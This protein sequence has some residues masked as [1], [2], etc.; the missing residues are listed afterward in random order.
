[1]GIKIWVDDVR[2]MPKGYDFHFHSV[3]ETIDAID[4]IEAKQKYSIDLL[5]LD[6]DAGEFC[7]DGGDYIRILDYLEEHNI[8]IPIH[9]HSANV[10]GVNNMKR[11]IEKNN[12]KY[13]Y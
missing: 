12:W 4:Y 3:N 5:S 7:V 8:F 6:H 2:P 1:M 9:I 10:V 13:V 11:I